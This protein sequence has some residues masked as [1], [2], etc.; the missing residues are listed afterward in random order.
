MSASSSEEVLPPATLGNIIPT[1]KKCN[2]FQ[3]LAYGTSDP[4]YKPSQNSKHRE[5]LSG[6]LCKDLEEP[7]N[8]NACFRF[9]K[10]EVEVTV[11]LGSHAD[12]S[13]NPGII[14][15]LLLFIP[16][17]DHVIHRT[18]TEQIDKIS[19]KFGAKIWEHAVVVLSGVGL[20]DG[21]RLND[22]MRQIQHAVRPHTKHQ[23]NVLLAGSKSQPD[24]FAPN[25]KWFSK[26]WVSC[27]LSSK[28]ASMPAL[29][30]IAQGRIQNKT[31]SLEIAEKEFYEQP[32]EVKE[33]IVEL[34]KS[35]KLGLGIGGGGA[36]AGAAAAG[37]TTGALIG[38][39]AIGIPSFGV[40][41]GAGLAIGALVGGGVG[42]GIAGAAVG[43]SYHLAKEKQMEEISIEDLGKYYTEL[44]ARTPKMYVF[45]NEWAEKQINC[46]IVVSGTEEEDVSTIAAALIGKAPRREGSSLYWKQITPLKTN[47]VV[48]DFSRESPY[49]ANSPQGLKQLSDLQ[50]K[51]T[52]HLLVIC[53]SITASR[54]RFA[55]SA[56]ADY[57]E[58]LCR[59][60]PH[61]L[62]NTVI[63]LSQANKIW[64]EMR[65]HNTAMDMSLQQYFINEVREWKTTIGE[66]LD[67]NVENCMV[68]NVIVMP[69]GNMEPSINL[70]DLNISPDERVHYYWVSELL[71]HAMS[72]TKLDGLPAL[73][74]TNR[75]RMQDFPEHYP[76]PEADE[77]EFV[78]LHR[79]DKEPRPQS[80]E[81]SQ[82]E[83]T[84]PDGV[85][86]DQGQPA[87]IVAQHREDQEAAEEHHQDLSLARDENL[88]TV[89]VRAERFD[90]ESPHKLFV[91]AQCKMFSQAG[92]KFKKHPG[93]AI[94]LILGVNEEQN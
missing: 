6:V 76:C 86:P 73:T 20:T 36:I 57:L 79:D 66:F 92:L 30:K 8:R 43:G 14:A 65:K 18:Y 90:S 32:I 50:K 26:L 45:L 15:L 40:A 64:D 19:Q 78:E 68:E 28:V 4:K 69:A 91:E 9:K 21:G 44:L 94:G 12:C 7:L 56:H 38:A 70:S 89:S 71:L 62:S 48:I 75:K 52:T 3:V 29:I 88:E 80:G 58:N 17:I 63:V 33:N 60:D 42:A 72:V 74:R 39:L 49:A 54:E 31:E 85:P 83:E 67:N 84:A 27:F 77:D 25:E 34:P 10:N 87:E 46:K 13:A 81:N 5:L 1:L 93:Q 23:I 24:L 82:D 37:A 59:Q 55:E 16:I 2:R 35:L 61:I 51:D 41:A 11:H 47:L 53:I 22:W